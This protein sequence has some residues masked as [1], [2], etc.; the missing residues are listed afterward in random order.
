[1]RHTFTTISQM[2]LKLFSQTGA[3]YET[4]IVGNEV[5]EKLNGDQI[6]T[7]SFA[8]F[9]DA[10]QY[11]WKELYPHLQSGLSEL[12]QASLE[13]NGIL[14]K[15]TYFAAESDPVCCINFYLEQWRW[16][17]DNSKRIAEGRILKGLE[18]GANPHGIWLEP[19]IAYASRFRL[20]NI[21]EAIL[22]KGV[23]IDSINS[24][25]A[26]G[27]LFQTPLSEIVIRG[28]NPDH[29]DKDIE[30]MEYLVSLGADVDFNIQL[31]MDFFDSD[32]HQAEFKGFRKTHRPYFE[33]LLSRVK[34]HASQLGDWLS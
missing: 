15:R 26:G 5:V 31:L 12:G 7:T 17:D 28:G 20:K 18:N 13:K 2:P 29:R 16:W 34:T 21:M 23:S 24:V 22:S 27:L 32:T 10:I 1:M 6:K 8:D 9:D 3:T 11:W 19:A 25:N 30:W 14:W 4:R 33:F